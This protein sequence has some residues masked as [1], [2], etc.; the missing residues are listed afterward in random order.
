MVSLVSDSYSYILSRVFLERIVF[1]IDG[2]VKFF[3][4]KNNFKWIYIFIV[5]IRGNLGFVEVGKVI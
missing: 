4:V 1:D 5:K 3:Y 2:L